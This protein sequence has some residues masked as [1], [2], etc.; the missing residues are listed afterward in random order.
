MTLRNMLKLMYFPREIANSE[1]FCPLFG[2]QTYIK[3]SVS[4]SSPSSYNQI[5][6]ILT[7]EIMA[8]VESWNAASMEIAGTDGCH[9]AD[10]LR[11]TANSRWLV[12]RLPSHGEIL[13]KQCMF[14][15]CCE[16]AIGRR[17]FILVLLIKVIH[18]LLA[19]EIKFELGQY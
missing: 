1:G 7:N 5:F 11:Y 16:L 10:G 4:S 14:L 2:F 12:C 6:F 18:Q 3:K 19:G 15:S 17:D 13:Q 8:S 9:S